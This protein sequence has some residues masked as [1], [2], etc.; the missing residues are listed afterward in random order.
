MTPDQKQAVLSLASGKVSTAQFLDLFGSADGEE[1][2]CELLADAVQRR[3]GGD[4]DLALVASFKF[5]FS[6]GS[7]PFLLDEGV[8]GFG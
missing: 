8:V 3:D 2:C 1:L 4:V 5:G 7:L 6:P